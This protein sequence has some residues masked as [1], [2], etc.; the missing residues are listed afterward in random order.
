VR[1][2][3]EALSYDALAGVLTL[4]LA[5]ASTVSAA[6]SSVVCTHTFLPYSGLWQTSCTSGVTVPT[7]PGTRQTPP[8]VILSGKVCTTERFPHVGTAKTCC[9]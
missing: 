9:R 5:L 3:R 2:S 7:V 6:P 8:T 1:P 4:A